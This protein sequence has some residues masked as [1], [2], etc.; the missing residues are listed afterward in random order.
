[1]NASGTLKVVQSGAIV[2]NHTGTRNG[3]ESGFAPIRRAKFPRVGSS[4][5]NDFQGL[6]IRMKMSE[7]MQKCWPVRLI[8]DR[9]GRKIISQPAQRCRE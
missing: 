2:S 7:L 1:M 5:R 6:E 9:G 3:F 8:T 4:I